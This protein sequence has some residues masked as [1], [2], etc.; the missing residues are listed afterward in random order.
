VW[1][2]ELAAELGFEDRER[3]YHALGAVLHAL[4]DRLTVAEAADLGAQLPTLIRGQ[5]YEGWNPNGKPVKERSREE[6]LAH[7][8]SAF[9]G[10][11]EIFPEGVAWAVFKVLEK[12]VTAGEIGDI[13]HVLP[14]HIRSLWPH[15]TA[16][17]V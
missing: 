2:K 11:G 8:A 12:H 7:I 3:V 1:L 6:F 5:Y 14:A 15:E 9:R 10:Q 4:R 16:G 13:K 17:H